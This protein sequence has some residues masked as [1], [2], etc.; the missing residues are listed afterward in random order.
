MHERHD[1]C[2]NAPHAFRS[3][4][5]ACVL[6]A[7]CVLLVASFQ[8]ALECNQVAL[9]GAGDLPGLARHSLLVAAAAPA[10]AAT[11]SRTLHGGSKE[12]QVTL[13]TGVAQVAN[14][15]QLLQAP[16]CPERG[17]VAGR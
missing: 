10:A 12:Y 11:Q 3:C 4:P 16:S 14:P 5:D 13:R 8:W 17:E 15:L 9:V 2:S 7:H 6:A 1:V